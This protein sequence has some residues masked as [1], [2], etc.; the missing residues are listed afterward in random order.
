M[1]ARPLTDDGASAA[2]ALSAG[3]QAY[4]AGRLEE[5]ATALDRAC[6]LD[7]DNAGAQ[8]T[9]GMALSGLGRTAAAE[10]AFR[11]AV[12]LAPGSADHHD[13]LGVFLRLDGRYAAAAAAHTTALGLDP[14]HLGARFNLALAQAA[15]GELDPAEENLRAVIAADPNR[16]SAL[17]SLTELL[18][19]RERPSDA[20]EFAVQAARLAP[21][22]AEA[23]LSL[24]KTLRKVKR[25]GDSLAP[26]RRAA[27]V[28]P[29][30]LS[31]LAPLAGS[32][33]ML[34]RTAMAITVL[35][36]A[37]A[38]KPTDPGLAAQLNFCLWFSP[39]V[40]HAEIAAENR[41]FDEVHCRALTLAAPGF[42]TE[43]NPDRR[44]RIGYVC[45]DFREHSN[46]FAF[47]RLILDRDRDR[48]DVC[49]YSGETASDATAR[50]LRESADGWRDTAELDDA[51]LV[52][53]V[54]RDEIDVLV[55]LA[56][57]T[58]GGR[59][60]AFARRAAPVQVSWVNPTGLTAMDWLITDAVMVP[61]RQDDASDTG[62]ERPAR[63]AVGALPFSPPE[64]CPPVEP[65]PLARGGGPVFGCFNNALKMNDMLFA[66]WGRLL[67]R[68]PE[69]RL[70]LKYQTLGD[71]VVR[72]DLLARLARHGITEDRVTLHGVTTR[73][74][75]LRRYADMDV[76]LDTF[77]GSG[78]VTTWE[79]LWM[80]VPVVS[81]AADRPNGRASASILR[82]IG[83]DGLVATTVEDYVA[84]AAALAADPGALAARRQ[85]LRQQAAAAPIL[86]GDT[87]VRAVE[88]CYRRIWRDWCGHGG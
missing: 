69:A 81:F 79:A 55:D 66:A 48:F 33:M 52:E 3:V 53:Q 32:L 75:H 61:P 27:A 37:M 57:Y 76:A 26:L 17:T 15:R 87:Y 59:L 10:R 85:G 49:L 67:E 71:P 25:F 43:R 47:G 23:Q 82:A 28:D 64:E 24:G 20:L 34:G 2:A 78:G 63:I 86:A 39:Q 83:L 41:R 73:Q 11:A 65:G 9:L 30:N 18:N 60:T 42:L 68:V 58:G 38:L 74:D 14:G 22:D 19:A 70:M 13:N 51:T 62:P 21:D 8:A 80:G 72:A 88:A 6:R 77:P 45:A 46:A 50:R 4:R 7:P 44:L 5:A 16:L 54:R 35:R 84:R 12:A 36:R 29:E 31:V 1:T 56:A 40:D